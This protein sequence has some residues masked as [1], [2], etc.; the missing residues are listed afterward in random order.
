MKNRESI[1]NKVNQGY[2]SQIKR[3][4]NCAIRDA[5]A[6]LETNWRSFVGAI[7]I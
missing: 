4:K 3:M 1:E 2:S 5:M 7:G 6:Q